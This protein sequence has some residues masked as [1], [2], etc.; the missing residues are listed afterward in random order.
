M[1]SSLKTYFELEDP[2]AD[3]PVPLEI[4]ETLMEAGLTADIPLSKRGEE[5]LDLQECSDYTPVTEDIPL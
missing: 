4:G 2:A 1:E 5:S 3:T